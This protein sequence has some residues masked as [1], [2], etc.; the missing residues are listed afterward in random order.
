MLKAYRKIM[1]SVLTSQMMHMGMFLSHD[2][3]ARQTS[4]VLK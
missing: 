3:E 4:L 1:A 2:S